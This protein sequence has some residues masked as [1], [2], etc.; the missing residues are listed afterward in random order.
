MLTCSLDLTRLQSNQT[1]SD[2]I[3]LLW[4]LNII[5]EDY[6]LMFVK[7]RNSKGWRIVGAVKY[8]FNGPQRDGWT[9]MGTFSLPHYSL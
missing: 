4:R 3:K 7:Y 5:T 2:Q 1:K 8:F 9:Q 6:L